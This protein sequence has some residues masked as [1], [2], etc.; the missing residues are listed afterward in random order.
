MTPEYIVA[1]A[2]WE[3]DKDEVPDEEEK[4]RSY[5]ATDLTRTYITNYVIRKVRRAP[6]KLRR[7][8]SVF[9]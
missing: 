2:K 1:E 4:V 3:L 7:Q 5:W 8:G 6:Q 9:H